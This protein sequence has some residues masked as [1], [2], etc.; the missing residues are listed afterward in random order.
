MEFSGR[1]YPG[2]LFR[3]RTEGE[4]SI[5]FV[6]RSMVAD[7]GQGVQLVGKR[8]NVFDGLPY[9]LYL[10]AHNEVSFTAETISDR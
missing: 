2:E 3:R 8:K 10:P 6:G 7:W 1:C 4:E 9:T 5:R